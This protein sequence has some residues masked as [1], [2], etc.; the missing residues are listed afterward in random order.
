MVSWRTR[1]VYLLHVMIRD[2]GGDTYYCDIRSASPSLSFSSLTIH[3]AWHDRTRHIGNPKFFEPN[4]GE[5]T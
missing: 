5:I 2:L 1:Q 3:P 4:P